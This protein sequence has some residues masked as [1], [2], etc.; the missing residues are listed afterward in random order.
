VTLLSRLERI[1]CGG[2]PQFSRFCSEKR[3]KTSVCSCCGSRCC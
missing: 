1:V 2:P 3:A